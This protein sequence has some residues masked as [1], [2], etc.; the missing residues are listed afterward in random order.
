M[1]R[2]LGAAFRRRQMQAMA[3]LAR[4]RPG[5][6]NCAGASRGVV[7]DAKGASADFRV[8][9]NSKVNLPVRRRRIR[10]I[11]DCA[12]FRQSQAKAGFGVD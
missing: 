11:A 1:Q 6:A 5:T 7:R 8:A 3:D 10:A 12:Q 9:T 2:G 4:F